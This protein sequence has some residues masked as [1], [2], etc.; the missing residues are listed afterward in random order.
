MSF[1]Q[2]LPGLII[3]LFDQTHLGDPFFAPLADT[4]A[5]AHDALDGPVQSLL[6]LFQSRDHGDIG[7]GEGH[8]DSED[9]LLTDAFASTWCV[10]LS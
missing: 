7:D 6:D 3:A 8:V 1:L 2:N 5:D 4:F 9:C 10:A